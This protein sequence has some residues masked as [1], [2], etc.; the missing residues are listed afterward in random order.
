MDKILIIE[1]SFEHFSQMKNWLEGINYTVLPDDFDE[2]SKCLDN[3]NRGENIERFAIRKIRENL[4]DVCLVLCDIKLHDDVQG[5][6]RVVSAI[7]R[8]KDADLRLLSTMIPI[9]GIT[10]YS[11]RRNG[12]VHDGADFVF[13]KPKKQ[14]TVEKFSSDI[15]RTVIDAQVSR[16]RERMTFLYP[17]TLKE[18]INRFRM[19]H[20]GRPTAFIMTSFRE[21]HLRTANTIISILERYGIDGCLASE[22]EGGIYSDNLWLNIEVYMHGCDF[23]IGIYADDRLLK[24]DEEIVE[25]KKA[26][27]NPNMSQEVGYML[28]LHKPV[29][30]LKH[31]KLKDIPSDLSGRIYVQYNKVNLENKLTSWLKSKR[32]V[33]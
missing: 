19:S 33:D 29:C 12:L 18:E 8:N 2:M 20:K 30:I 3:A 22:G 31:Y 14:Q 10:E 1:D 16:F 9:I 23:G 25:M 21:Q 11:D 6:N 17:D 13:L 27:I 26:R 4:R 15:L 5:G 28:A 32:I 7:R 24:G